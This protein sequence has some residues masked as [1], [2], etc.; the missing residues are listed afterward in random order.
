MFDRI[1]KLRKRVED[2]DEKIEDMKRRE[3]TL[4][5]MSDS[6]DTLEGGGAKMYHIKG[7]GKSFDELS[8]VIG[9]DVPWSA[10]TVNGMYV[11]SL[12]GPYA[13]ITLLMTVQHDSILCAEVNSL[14]D[15]CLSM[16]EKEEGES[17]AATL[18]RE[19]EHLYKLS[20]HA[21]NGMGSFGFKAEPT[22]IDSVVYG[23]MSRKQVIKF[24]I[25]VA[26][27]HRTKPL[28]FTSVPVFNR[29]IDLTAKFW[30]D[31]LSQLGPAAAMEAL[32]SNYEG[33]A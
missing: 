31:L 7:E 29:L 5:G 30:R 9:G 14:L 26:S 11:V 3:D 32:G 10:L 2:R 12:P 17:A 13:L 25:S 24:A 15:A 18:V 4:V 20:G 19:I 28:E 23:L 16:A 6:V 22:G 27:M 33:Q 1:K 21:G 8:E